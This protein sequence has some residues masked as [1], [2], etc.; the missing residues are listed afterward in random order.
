[1]GISRED[2]DDNDDDDDDNDDNNPQQNFERVSFAKMHT[3]HCNM[4]YGTINTF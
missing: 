1:M 4:Y 3:T 2:D